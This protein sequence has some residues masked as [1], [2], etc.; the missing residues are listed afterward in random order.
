MVQGQ[1]I[2]EPGGLRCPGRDGDPAGSQDGAEIGT[3]PGVK[4]AAGHQRHA[5]QPQ[6][7]QQAAS[8]LQPAR[9]PICLRFVHRLYLLP[10]SPAVMVARRRNVC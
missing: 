2:G 6:Q 3:R 10:S 4:Q 7:Q 5:Q 9:Y 8:Q 1:G